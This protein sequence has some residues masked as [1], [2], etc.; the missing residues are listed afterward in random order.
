MKNKEGPFYLRVRGWPVRVA[1]QVFIDSEKFYQK[2]RYFCYELK[3]EKF[4][5]DQEKQIAVFIP[6]KEYSLER[7]IEKG[8]QFEDPS[9]EPMDADLI[10]EDLL[11]LLDEALLSLT[12]EEW[13][14]VQELY[15]LGKTEREVGESLHISKSTI[16][17]RKEAV[18]QKLRNFAERF[19]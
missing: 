6:P 19:F 16:H 8:F 5:C 18:L 2:E 15:Y 9:S 13:L 7:M 14:L 12:D 1:K 10:K 4:I 17:R 3:R 11:N